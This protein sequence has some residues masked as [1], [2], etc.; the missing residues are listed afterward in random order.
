MRNLTLNVGKGLQFVIDRDRLNATVLDHAIYLGLKNM[1]QDAHATFTKKDHPNYIELSKAACE[2]KIAAL[3]EG[4][5]RT[6]TPTVSVEEIK[7]AMSIEELEALLK[8][9][10]AKAKAA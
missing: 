6:V 7:Q 9:K 8:A 4:Q 3:Y 5:I 1:V 10:K 2:R